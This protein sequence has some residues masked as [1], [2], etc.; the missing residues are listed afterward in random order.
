L[1]FNNTNMKVQVLLS[2]YNGEKYI[3]EQILSILAQDYPDIKILVRDDGSTDRTVEILER[4]AAKHQIIEIV[5]ANN[6]GFAQ[7]FFQLLFNSSTEADYIAFCDQ[8]D[9]WLE[10]K[11][12]RAVSM[13]S[14]CPLNQPL[15]YCSSL[16]IVDEKLRPIAS[17]YLPQKGISFYNALVENVAVG[18]TSVLNQ[19]ARKLIIDSLPQNVLFHDWWIYLVISAFGQVI[20]DYQSSILYRRHSGNASMY[21]TGLINSFS[22]LLKRFQRYSKYRP[23][24][25]QAEEFWRIYGRMLPGEFQFELANLLKSQKSF[26]SRLRYALSCKLYRHS[27]L[28]NQA[29]R[30]MILINRL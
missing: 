18:C 30:L 22:Y 20:Y 27:P 10:N 23:V 3:E 13:L 1:W 29:L 5:K 14:L 8:D 11:I 16:K 17:S 24:L 21:P 15:L 28:D 26:I 7:S 25:R 4:L 9:I 19:V 6:I 2:T 12:S